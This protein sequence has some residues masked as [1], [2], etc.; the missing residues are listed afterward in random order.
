[1][2]LESGYLNTSAYVSL[3]VVFTLFLLPTAGLC[4]YTF[5]TV[6][7][8]TVTEFSLFSLTSAILGLGLIFS[9][10]TVS[11]SLSSLLRTDAD[12]MLP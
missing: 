5:S 9:E 11:P 3:R 10:M 12:I 7:L 2:V 8:A 1:M 4:L 6:G